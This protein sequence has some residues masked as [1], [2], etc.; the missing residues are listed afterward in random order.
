VQ[1]KEGGKM[2]YEKP[3]CDDCGEELF[4]YEEFSYALETKINKNGIRSKRPQRSAE[5]SHSA[6]ERLRCGTCYRE[7]AFKEDQKSRIIK[8]MS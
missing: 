1:Q 5:L 7:W 3:K 8:V 4:L 6:Y 2:P